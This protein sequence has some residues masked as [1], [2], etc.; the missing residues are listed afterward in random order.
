MDWLLP[1]LLSLAL[2]YFCGS[3]PFGWFAGK[4]HGIDIREHGS[5]NIGATNVIR[6]CGK[7]IGIPV[8]ILDV[9][10]GWFPAWFVQQH[11]ITSGASAGVVST[12][13][14]LAG[15]AAVLGHNYTCWLKGRGGK[16]VASSLGMLLGCAPVP[17]VIGF[18]SWA[19]VAFTTKYV[20]LGSIVASVV[21]PVSLAVMMARAGEWNWVLLGFVSLLGVV[22]ILRHKPNIQRLLA[23]TES[24]MGQKKT[25]V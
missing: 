10:K 12:L 3:I 2:G 22:T 15:V 24:K 1:T 20:S 5:K 21:V 16:G 9:L 14:I 13:G 17:G 11:Y 19:L 7:G 25:A 23:G 4:L 18:L 8:F 6:V